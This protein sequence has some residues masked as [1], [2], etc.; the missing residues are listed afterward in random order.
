MVL[1]T[2]TGDTRESRT[3]ADGTYFIGRG[4]SCAVRFE[5]PD[6]SE[7]HAI[8]TVRG[9]EAVIEDLHSANGTYVNG[10]PIDG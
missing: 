10:E 1:T 4:E 3:I 5:S 9:G 2:L 6:V 7:R 8:L